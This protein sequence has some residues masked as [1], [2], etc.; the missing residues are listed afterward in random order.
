MKIQ[1]SPKLNYQFHAFL[2][3]FI[4]SNT[5]IGIGIFNYERYIF[6]VAGHD[7]WI[8][9]LLA[10]VVTHLMIWII[11]RALDKYGSADLF[12][13]NYDLFGKWAGSLLNI[14]YLIYYIVVTSLILRDYI[15]VVQAWVFPDLSTWILALMIILLSVYAAYGGIR[16]IIGMCVL[17]FVVIF[18]TSIC[19]Y[20]PLRY[21]VW[22]QLLPIM[23]TDPAKILRGAGRMSFSLAGFEVLM[24]IYPYIRDKAKANLYSQL[25]LLYTNVVYIAILIIAI[26]YFSPCQLRRSIWPS[27]NL[28]K[29]A[30]FSFLERIEFI[31]VSLWMLLALTGILL[32]MW[33]VT[34]GMKRMWGWNSKIVLWGVSLIILTVAVY[35]ESHE[36]I[37]KYSTWVGKASIVYSYIYPAILCLIIMIVFAFRKRK[38]AQNKGE[39]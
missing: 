19:F 23:E 37:E 2:L 15:E 17:G 31:I 1:V 36:Q 7:A 27:I 5:Q 38:Q 20:Y 26:V 14:L 10:G 6:Q 28:L 29:I 34:R 25:S 24:I 13:I 12:G 32:N 33:V 11:T 16:V 39:T 4:I 22:T 18:V 9:V 3:F 21:S 8:S 35:T 30:K